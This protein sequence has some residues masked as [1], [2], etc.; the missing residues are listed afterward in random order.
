MAKLPL[1]YQPG[2]TWDYS[3]ATD[4]LGRVIEVVAGKPL[5]QAF[6]E[7]L[8]EPLGMTDTSFYLTDPAK[9]AAPRRAIR[10]RPHD[11]RRGRCQ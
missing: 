7:M 1:V 8:F 4:V 10:R 9:Y 5:Y 3:H 11:R 6:R 2:T